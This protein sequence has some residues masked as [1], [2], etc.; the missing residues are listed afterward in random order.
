MIELQCINNILAENNI[1]SY[2]EE[3]INADFFPNYK[4]EWNYILAHYKKYSKV[5]DQATFLANFTEFDL[6]DVLEPQ[7]Y[8]LEN[9]REDYVF[10]NAADLFNESVELLKQNAFEGLRNILS[11]G[12]KL[13]VNNSITQGTDINNIVNQ[14]IADINSKKGTEGILGISTGLKELDDILGGWLPGEELVT[15]VGRVNQ[16][17]SW[18]LQKFLTAAHSQGK[19][20]LLY[21]GEMSAMQVGYRHDTLALNY[22]NR[23]LT[24]GTISDVQFSNYE[25]DLQERANSLQPFIV[26]T[27]KDLGGKYMTVSTL[28]ALIKKYTPDIVGID[29]L[30]LMDDERKGEN[31]R[32]Q[33]SNITMDL[34]RIS[35]ELGLPILADAQANRNK[36]NTEEPENPELADIGESDAIGQNSS[37]VISLVQTKLGLSLLIT[38]NRYGE[39]NKKFIYSWDIDLGTFRFVSEE[40][41][42]KSEPELP[43]KNTSTNIPTGIPDVTDV[44]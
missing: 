28:K 42:I 16:G 12:E 38:K 35:E 17:K 40:G 34:F 10:R 4:K 11:K 27:P 37:R 13:L 31:R 15:I 5:P 44:F 6:L 36:T 39:N 18:L 3:G 29:Q 26:V 32:L 20:I 7:K 9:L 43:F 2:L 8:L 23:Q 25:N 22:S 19:R 30:S 33:L 21:S 14:K 1:D 41:Q 24:R